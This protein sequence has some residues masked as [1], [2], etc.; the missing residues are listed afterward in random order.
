MN[1]GISTVLNYVRYESKEAEFTGMSITIRY[2]SETNTMHD[3][4]KIAN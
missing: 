1:L 3:Y 2:E 4:K